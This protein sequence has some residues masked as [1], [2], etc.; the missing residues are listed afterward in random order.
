MIRQRALAWAAVLALVATV[1]VAPLPL[2]LDSR[3][4]S[5]HSPRTT[6]PL[7]PASQP[8]W[9]IV[10]LHC[11]EAPA[12]EALTSFFTRWSGPD[13]VRAR[14]GRDHRRHGEW[15]SRLRRPIHDRRRRY[16]HRSPSVWAPRSR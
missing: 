6:P 2:Q 7:M 16:H 10:A 4:P 11:A 13:R 5:P 15:G 1:Q 9:Q 3:P 14:R 8:I 12:A